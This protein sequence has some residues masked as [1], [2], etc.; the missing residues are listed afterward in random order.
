MRVQKITRSALLFCSSVL[1][2]NGCASASS[3]VAGAGTPGSIGA[4][5][6]G[7]MIRMGG[8]SRAVSVGVTATPEQVWAALPGV[9][10]ELGITAEMRDDALRTIGTRAFTGA[11]IGGK[12]VSDF[13]RCG[14][15]GSGPSS[16]GMVRHRLIIVTRVT[17]TGAGKSDLVTEVGGTATPVEGTSTGPITCASTGE[18]EQRIKVMAEKAISG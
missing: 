7:G 6:T 18:L 14:N 16:G 2:L 8:D 13:V 17:A 9:Y 12:R 10:Q 5:E 3:P 15:Q 4:T 1:L 11:R